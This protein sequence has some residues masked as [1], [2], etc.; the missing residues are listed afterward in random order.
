MTNKDHPPEENST[1]SEGEKV[2]ETSEKSSSTEDLAQ[3][4]EAAQKELLY[5]RAEFDN[6]RKN[7]IRE[8]SDLIKYGGEP[9]IRDLLNIID[10]FDTALNSDVSKENIDSFKQGFE[11]VASEFKAT[12]KRFGVQEDNPIGAPFDPNCHEA[13]SSEETSEHPA[14]HIARVFKKA[15]RLHDK[16]VRPAQVIVATEPK[17]EKPTGESN[18]SSL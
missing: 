15:Y 5:L 3:Q 7:M 11:M 14:G 13:I 2:E 18:D 6:Y 8:R 9:L 12:L 17:D 10:V 4:L 1:K 16:L